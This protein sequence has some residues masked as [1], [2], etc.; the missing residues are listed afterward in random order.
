MRK[1][2]R[3]ETERVKENATLLFIVAFTASLVS[4]QSRTGLKQHSVRPLRP[5]GSREETTLFP[6]DSVQTGTRLPL[7]R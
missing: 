7:G 6:S 1:G 2:K 4:Y 5:I 3:T